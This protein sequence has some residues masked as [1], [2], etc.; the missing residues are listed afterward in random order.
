QVGNTEH[1]SASDW[2]E[3]IKLAQEAQIDAFALNMAR[4]EPMNAK[5]IADAFSNAEALVFK[6]FFSFSFD[7]F[8]RGPFSKDEVVLWINKYASSSAYFRH[9]GKPFVSTFEGPDQAED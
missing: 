4:G 1:Y 6:L 2:I 5:A 8:G 3:D 9:Q 7:H